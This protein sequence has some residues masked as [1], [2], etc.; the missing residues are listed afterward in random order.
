MNTIFKTLHEIFDEIDTYAK[1]KNIHNINLNITYDASVEDHLSISV[2]SKNKVY[3]YS[4]YVE[5]KESMD[6]SML[7]ID[8]KQNID[9]LVARIDQHRLR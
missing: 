6:R 2:S 5:Y 7:I 9:T 3:I 8:I 1:S 4:E